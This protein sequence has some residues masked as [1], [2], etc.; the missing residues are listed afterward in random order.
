M[1]QES[2]PIKGV[3]MHAGAI[4]SSASV[5][6]ARNDGHPNHNHARA[7]AAAT[8][9]AQPPAPHQHTPG[10]ARPGHIDVQA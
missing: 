2:N 7:G 1:T 5:V 10:A 6:P 9:S 3:P 8:P 4:T